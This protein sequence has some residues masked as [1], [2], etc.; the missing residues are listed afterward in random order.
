MSQ[1]M[2]WRAMSRL[3][4]WGRRDRPDW[5]R[6]PSG[7]LLGFEYLSDQAVRERVR[8]MVADGKPKAER[9]ERTLAEF[10]RQIEDFVSE[11]GYSNARIAVE[12]VWAA[13]MH[14]VAYTHTLG[15]RFPPCAEPDALTAS[16][17]AYRSPE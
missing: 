4:E 10:V 8:E 15:D 14:G 12:W 9:G 3:K 1:A 2:F 6:L 17:W 16:R 5:R 7:L 11:Q 13:G